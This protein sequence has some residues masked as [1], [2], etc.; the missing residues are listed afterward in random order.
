MCSGKYG[1]R[2]GRSCRDMD[3]KCTNGCNCRK[4]IDGKT[5]E[6]CKKRMVRYDIERY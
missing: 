2:R 5:V 6:M 3:Q 1:E 4:K